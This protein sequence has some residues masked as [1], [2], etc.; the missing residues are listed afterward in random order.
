MSM[1]YSMWLEYQIEAN[2]TTPVVF[3]LYN[4]LKPVGGSLL[5][6]AMY[7]VVTGGFLGGDALYF[8]YIGNA[9]YMLVSQTLFSVGWIVHDD[10]EHYQVIKYLY[11]SPLSYFTYLIGRSAMRFLLSILPLSV[12]IVLGIFLKV[13]YNIDILLLVVTVFLGWV[14][15]VS[16]GLLLCGINML[17]ARHGE[18]VGQAFAGIFYLFSGVI[19][20][21]NALPGWAQTFSRGLPSTYW[22]SLVRRSVLGGEIDSIMS[23]FTTG[24]AAGILL[25]ISAIFFV[26]SY[27]TFRF[28]DFLARKKGIL[29][30]T[31]TY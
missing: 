23:T 25:V 17:T 20:P 7:Y 27:L 5:L 15:I 28:A 19:F 22:F 18:S 2:W 6:L 4:T 11:I 12:L 29:D 10:R 8:L 31:T 3:I 14:F 26:I 16:A 30:M 13:P 21:L 24:E 9:F 1:K